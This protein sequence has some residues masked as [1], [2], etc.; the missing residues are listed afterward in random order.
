MVSAGGQRTYHGLGIWSA[1]GVNLWKLGSISSWSGVSAGEAGVMVSELKTG[2]WSKSGV[3]VWGSGEAGVT[4]FMVT[5][6][7]VSANTGVIVCKVSANTGSDRTG[8]DTK[9][10][11]GSAQNLGSWSARSHWGK[12]KHR[13]AQNLGKLGA[14]N[15]RS[16][17]WGN[18]NRGIAANTG[19]RSA[20]G[21]SVKVSANTGGQWSA[22]GYICKVSANKAGLGSI[23]GSW[24]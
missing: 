19:L 14:F 16:Q 9:T 3:M 6:C 20:L 12:F 18:R 11:H 24:G 5:V 8:E 7:K 2:Q 1:L 22:L 17:F 10:G 23:T 15:M 4:I 21:V 13:S